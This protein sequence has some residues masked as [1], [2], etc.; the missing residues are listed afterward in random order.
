[1]L[2]YADVIDERALA[3]DVLLTGITGFRF[4]RRRDLRVKPGVIPKVGIALGVGLLVSLLACRSSSS[5]YSRRCAYFA[6]LLVVRGIPTPSSRT[7]CCTAAAID[8]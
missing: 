7:R 4:T 6:V 1:V 3:A 5:S 2:R 8:A